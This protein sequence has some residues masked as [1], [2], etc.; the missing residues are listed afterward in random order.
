MTKKRIFVTGASGC[1]GHYISETLIQETDYELYLLVRNPSKLQVDTQVRPGV[2]VLQGDMQNISQFAD[3]LS[4]IDIA[5][6]TATAWGGEQ[7]FDINVSKT[8][9][10][11]NLLDPDRCQQV[12]Y[13]STASVLDSQNQPLK[14]AGE[15]GTDYI[16]SKYECLHKISELGIASKIT[17]V[18][19]TLVLGGDSKKPYSHIRYPRSYQVC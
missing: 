9:E 3:L 5:I 17:T 2:T 19:P 13:F 15:I 12:I 7:T 11:L 4:T 14:E 8:I 10:L 18:F 16:R 6:L 1:I